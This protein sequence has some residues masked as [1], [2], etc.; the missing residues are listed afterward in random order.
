MAALPLKHSVLLTEQ[1][2][3][4][5]MA[6]LSTFFDVQTRLSDTV[7][8]HDELVGWLH[9]KAGVIADSRFTFD[10]PLIGRLPTLK[11]VCNLDAAHHNLDLQALT[12]AGIRATHTPEPDL[13]WR[14]TQANAQRTWQAIQP[15]LARA[16]P[17]AAEA[18][19]YG[20]WTRKVLLGSSLRATRL[21]ILGEQRFTEA[22]TA[23]AQAAQVTVWTDRE[24]ALSMADVLVVEDTP[25]HAFSAADRARMKSTTCVY[26]LPASFALTPDFLSQSWALQ[27]SNIAAE[28]MVASLGFGRNSWHPQYLLNPDISCD[29]CC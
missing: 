5:A 21:G 3:H 10:A 4:A 1:L 17:V 14:A 25:A 16:V 15:L 27:R 8:S 18:G 9:G 6:R 11:A 26:L 22:L 7:P 28:S 20:A 19:R 13:A 2:P 24:P 12:Q 29:S 23:L